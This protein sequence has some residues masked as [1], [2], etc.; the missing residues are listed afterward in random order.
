[1]SANMTCQWWT[2]ADTH[3]CNLDAAHEGDH[4]CNCGRTFNENALH[5]A[6]P[7]CVTDLRTEKAN[8]E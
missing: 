8:H 6:H 1:M 4:T 3:T 7:P 2:E 5:P